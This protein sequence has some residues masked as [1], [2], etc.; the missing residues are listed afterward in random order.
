M[1]NDIL[2]KRIC[3][4]IAMTY[5]LSENVV[6]GAYLKTNSIDMVLDLIKQNKI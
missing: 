5:A 4:L 6:Y 1:A 3:K 2:M